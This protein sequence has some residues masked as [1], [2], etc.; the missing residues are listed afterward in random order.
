MKVGGEDADFELHSHEQQ[1][2]TYGK[3]SA[4]CVVSCLKCYTYPAF[5]ILLN[6]YC[7]S[8]VFILSESCCGRNARHRQF[9]HLGL[10]D[11][12]ALL[13]SYFLKSRFAL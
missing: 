3:L 2:S 8:G 5:H 6:S 13:E 11:D 4:L 1:D 12:H 9:R 10:C 7:M